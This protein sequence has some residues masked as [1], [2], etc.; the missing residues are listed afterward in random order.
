MTM[1]RTLQIVAA[2]L[3]LFLT[4]ALA[5]VELILK[6]GQTVRG[7]DVRLDGDNYVECNGCTP[8]AGDQCGDC[9][10]TDPYINPGEMEVCPNGVDEDCDGLVDSD[11]PDCTTCRDFDGDGYVVCDGCDP[12]PSMCGECDQGNASVNPG[13]TEDCGN[14]I[15]DDC[16]TFVDAGDP[17]RPDDEDG[18]RSDMGAI[19]FLAFPFRRGDVDG[20]GVVSPLVDAYALPQMQSGQLGAALIGGVVSIG[21]LSLCSFIVLRQVT[22]R[23]IRRIDQ[24]NRQLAA[25]LSVARTLAGSEH[26]AQTQRIIK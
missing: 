2:T 5:D 15:D 24:D 13:A 3:A 26:I 8:A 11:D 21:V 18:T 9:D 23:T 1:R 16:D 6:D 7:S 4:V 22:R 25:L 10:E 12:G 17:E 14:G 20:N 19:S